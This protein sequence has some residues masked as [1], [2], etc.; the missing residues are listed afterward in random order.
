[1]KIGMLMTAA[2]AL[3]LSP[4]LAA[5]GGN[6]ELSKGQTNGVGWGSGPSFEVHPDVECGDDD[7][8]FSPGGA[9]SAQGSAFN[10]DGTAHGVYAG[11][12][13][14][15]SVNDASKSMYDVACLGGPP[16]E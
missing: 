14:H 7:A 16:S 4:A 13:T 12:Q 15:N 9:S 8:L 5:P 3:A 2:G 11:E 1:M 6:G 10:E